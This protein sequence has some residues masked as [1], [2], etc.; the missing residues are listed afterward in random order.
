M[1]TLI[2]ATALVLVGCGDSMSHL[3]LAEKTIAS[4]ID[5][6]CMNNVVYY[7]YFTAGKFALAPKLDTDS[8]I[9]TCNLRSR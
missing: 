1:K 2:F 9:E 5:E 7:T 8:K 6:V 4:S 3:I